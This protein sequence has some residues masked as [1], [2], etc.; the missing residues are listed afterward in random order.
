L[1]RF[2]FVFHF[3]KREPARAAGIAVGH[4]PGAIDGAVPFKQGSNSLFGDIEIEVAHEN[5]LHT[6]LQTI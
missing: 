6:I 2:C 5:I 3:Y 1:I 4:N